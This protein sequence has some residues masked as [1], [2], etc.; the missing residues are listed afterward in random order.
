MSF[1]GLINFIQE[2]SKQTNMN[3]V[4]SGEVTSTSPLLVRTNDIDLDKEELKIATSAKSGLTT[5]DEVLLIK[6]GAFFIVVA[7]VEE[8]T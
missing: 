3:F 1:P 6:Q 8:A 4:F 5:G 2:V 7:K